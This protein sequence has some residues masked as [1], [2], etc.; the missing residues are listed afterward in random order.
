MASLQIVET[1]ATAFLP[2]QRSVLFDTETT[3]LD[4]AS[5]DRIIEI[6]AIELIR[7]LPTGK[8]FHHLID[9]QRD[10][11]EEATRIHGFSRS[12]LMGKPQFSAIVDEFLAFIGDAPL[13]A[14]NAPFDFGFI[15]AELQRLSLPPLELDRM[16]DTLAL[17]KTRFP[18]MPNS[19]NALC[20]RFAIDLSERTTHN[21]LLDCRLLADVY[22]ELTGGRQRGLTLTAA[23]QA[24]QSFAYTRPTSRTPIIVIPTSVQLQAHATLVARLK[25]PVWQS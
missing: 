22:V 7:D 9:P 18:G 21:A 11:P 16:I 24:E 25:D 15:N 4:P 10:I 1:T 5:G 12:D 3:G 23:S 6:A 8:I 2:G 17:A 19:L 13:V 14:H 20:G